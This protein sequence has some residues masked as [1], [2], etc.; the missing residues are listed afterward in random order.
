MIASVEKKYLS[1]YPENSHNLVKIYE[2]MNKIMLFGTMLP[3]T[4]DIKNA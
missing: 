1:K 2:N 4:E 3:G